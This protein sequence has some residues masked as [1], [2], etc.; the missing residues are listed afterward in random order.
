V[1]VYISCEAWQN[2]LGGT[3]SLCPVWGIAIKGIG[4]CLYVDYRSGAA[5]L[6]DPLPSGSVVIDTPAEFPLGCCACCGYIQ[7]PSDHCCGGSMFGYTTTW[8]A[9]CVVDTVYDEHPTFCCGE[10]GSWTCVMTGTYDQY[11]NLGC[12][13]D[14]YEWSGTVTE[15]GS[16]S[17][18]HIQYGDCGGTVIGTTGG[19]TTIS[20]CG[21]S[22]GPLD[23]PGGCQFPCGTQS[24]SMRI[25][26]D[27]GFINVSVNNS[28]CGGNRFVYHA[29]YSI[30]SEPGTCG[31]DHCGEGGGELFAAALTA[32]LEKFVPVRK[33]CRGCRRRRLG[34][35][36]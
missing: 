3:A 11:D 15:G 5:G 28:A 4:Y 19:E 26:C 6:P 32:P 8:G 29:S 17:Y 34:E 33:G 9:A 22:L 14:H 10:E 16:L 36:T 20:R 21:F 18:T 30:V 24:G 7:G 12:L 25:N 27:G 23:P 2:S 35:G 1:T 31:N 13:T